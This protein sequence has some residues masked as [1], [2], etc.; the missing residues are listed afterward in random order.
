MFEK[1]AYRLS[2]EMNRQTY[3]ESIGDINFPSN[4]LVYNVWKC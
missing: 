2:L 4:D 1:P 3:F